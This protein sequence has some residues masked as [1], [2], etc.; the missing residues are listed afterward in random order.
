MTEKKRMSSEK[1]YMASDP[2]LSKERVNARRI[3]RLFNR[4]V[5]EQ[6]RIALL[7]ELFERAGENF[8]IEPPFYC[9]Y[10]YNISI[11]KNFFANFDCIII[12]VCKV[13]IGDNVLFGPRVCVYTAGH[14]IDAVVRNTLLEFGKPVII[15]NNVWIGGNVIINP[16][17]SIGNNV[18]IGSGSVVTKDMPDNVIAVGNPCKILRKINEYDKQYWEEK[19]KEYTDSRV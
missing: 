10:G 17:I 6:N 1:L 19:R 15:R 7:K 14:P 9:D 12:D 16:G 5:E 3:I 18:V 13:I 2:E 11:G 8:Y 4:T